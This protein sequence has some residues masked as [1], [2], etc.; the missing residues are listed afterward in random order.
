MQNQAPAIAVKWLYL[1]IGMAV[2]VN[3]SGLFVPIAGPD[4]TLYASIAKTMA[5]RNNFVDLYAYGKDW[6]DKPHFPFW[7]SALSFKLFGINTWAYKLPAI[8]FLFIGAA[9]TYLFGKAL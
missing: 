3:L 1:F 6:L 8:L 5:Q 7:I 4:G 9:Y 2:M